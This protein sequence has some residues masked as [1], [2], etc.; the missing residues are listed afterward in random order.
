MSPTRARIYLQP[1]LHVNRAWLKVTLY[2]HPQADGF[3]SPP[4]FSFG[5]QIFGFTN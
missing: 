2:Q 4:K 3:L 1:P 5:F